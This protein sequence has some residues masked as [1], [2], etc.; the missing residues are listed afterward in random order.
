MRGPSTFAVALLGL[1]LCACARGDDG[2]A[3]QLTGGDPRRGATAI[4]NYGCGAC[5]AIPGIRNASATVGPP[6]AGIANRSYLAGQLQNTPPNM[7]QWIQHP[8]NVEPGTAMPDMK[9]T[10]QDARDISAYLYTLR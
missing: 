3:A 8:Q 4:G 7:L 6:L 5:H 9:V 2:Q 1:A 10:E